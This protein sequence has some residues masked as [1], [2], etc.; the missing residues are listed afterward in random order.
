MKN[1]INRRDATLG[2][3]TAFAALA[4]IGGSAAADEAVSEAIA[5]EALNPWA[6]ALFSGD[7]AKIE[8]VLAPEYQILRSDGIGYDRTAYLQ[9]LPK[10]KARSKFKDIKA[11]GSGDLLVLRYMIE[12]DQTINGQNVEAVSPRLSVF[13]KDSGRWLM[14]AHANFAKLG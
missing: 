14:V 12:T 2:F 7:P 5:L 1:V 3:V 9:S 8:R 11:T 10:Q 13:R 6:D 4:V